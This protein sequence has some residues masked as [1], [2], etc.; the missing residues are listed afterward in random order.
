MVVSIGCISFLLFFQ[1]NGLLIVCAAEK[2]LSCF[3]KYVIITLIHGSAAVLA[4]GHEF[5]D[6]F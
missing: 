6:S 4:K 5:M 1:A 3:D 2:N